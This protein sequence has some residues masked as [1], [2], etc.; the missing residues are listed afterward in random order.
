MIRRRSILSLVVSS[1]LAYPLSQQIA[2]LPS[3]EVTPNTGSKFSLKQW[4]GSVVIVNFWATW[5]GPCRQEMKDLQEVSEKYSGQIQVLGVALDHL[6]WQVV[7]PFLRQYDIRFPV[8]LSNRNLLR[9]FGY[10]RELESVPQTFIFKPDGQL[11]IHI[12]TAL[13]AADFSSIVS[14]IRKSR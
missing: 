2:E 10:Q 6:G 14:H 4:K 7:T 11:A 13:S 12:R 5:C 3:I 9:A 1:P 8:T